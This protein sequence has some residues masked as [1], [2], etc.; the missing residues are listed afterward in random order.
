LGGHT[1]VPYRLSPDTAEL[2]TE[3]FY[4]PGLKDVS[5]SAAS[6][7]SSYVMGDGYYISFNPASRLESEISLP[8]AG[9]GIGR[10]VEFNTDIIAVLNAYTAN[11]GVA[12]PTSAL[13]TGYDFTTDLANFEVDQ[14]DKSGITDTESLISDTWTAADLRERLL[15]DATP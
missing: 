12:N 3:N 1:V 14:L 8:D 11:G 10:I 6:L 2:E 9:L 5:K 13:V 7:A 4:N 15:G